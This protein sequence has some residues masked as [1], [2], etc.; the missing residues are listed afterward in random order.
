[1]MCVFRCLEN[2]ATQG[3]EQEGSVQ[4]SGSLN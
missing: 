1:M 4:G 3:L 2:I